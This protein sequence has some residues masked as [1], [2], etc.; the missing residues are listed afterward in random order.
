MVGTIILFN[1]AIGIIEQFL[2]L[3]RTYVPYSIVS[4][5]GI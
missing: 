3:L 2:T 5:Y 1:S 4:D